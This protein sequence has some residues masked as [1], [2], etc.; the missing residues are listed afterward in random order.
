LG[1]R[2][3]Q[4]GSGR[5]GYRVIQYRVILGFG[6]YQVG[7]GRV[8][9]HLVLGHFGFWIV[10]GRVGSGIRLF[11]VELF[12]IMNRIELERLGSDPA[13]SSF[14]YDRSSKTNTNNVTGMGTYGLHVV[15]RRAVFF[16][17]RER[18]KIP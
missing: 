6:S 9:G 8:S 12:R 4:V 14:Y 11:S 3:Y 10:S 17:Y 18:V 13:T 16:I 1:F 15:G 2:S 7:L 5:V